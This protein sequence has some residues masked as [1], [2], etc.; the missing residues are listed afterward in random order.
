MF[1]EMLAN[2]EE[3]VTDIIFRVHLEAGAKARSVWQ[4]SQTLHDEVRQFAM[5]ERQRAAARHRR[6]KYK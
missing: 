2:V 5:A 6:A 4:V 1:N 3:R